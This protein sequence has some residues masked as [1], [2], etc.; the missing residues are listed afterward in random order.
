MRMSQILDRINK[1]NDIKNIEPKYYERLAGEIR[2]FLINK[3]SKSGGHF[4]SNLGVIELTMALHL[5]LD[6]P[7]DK[8]IWDVGHQAYAHKLLTGRKEGFN[9][10]RRYNGMAGFPKMEESDCDAFNVG[11]SS[12]SISVALG[13]ARARDINNENYKVYAVI[14]DGALSGGMAF[15]ALNNLARLKS[16]LVV[17]LNDNKMSI[18]ENVG[19]MANYLGKIRTAEKY[20]TLKTR[21]KRAIRK[22]PYG[23]KFI[24]ERIS[25][26]K[27]SI[28]RLVIPGMLFEDMGL[29]YIGPIDGHDINQLMYAFK[30]ASHAKGPVI[31]HVVTR[32]GKGY[33][34]A[35]KNPTK[36][37]GIDSNASRAEKD[38]NNGENV[39]YTTAFANK[40]IDIA[41]DNEKV[42]AVSAAML[43]G[44]GLNKFGALYPKRLFDV[45]IAEEHA[46]TF[47][48]G[49]AAGG[50]TPVVAIYSTF[51]QRAYDQ[52][53]H[54]ICI[55][56]HHVVLAIDR[57]GIVGPDGDTH[58][59]IYDT[60]FLRTIPNLT[61]M[62]PKNHR[63][64]DAMLEYAINEY[65]GPIAI[66]YPKGK[67]YTGLEEYQAPI[68]HG[69]AEIL[70]EEKEIMLVAF[71]SM[72]TVAYEVR[73]ML[74]ADGHRVS[75][76]N[77]RFATHIDFDTLKDLSVKHRLLVVLEE[78]VYTGGIGQEVMARMH[79]DRINIECMSVALPD[80][81][82]EH[83]QREFLLKK[84]GLDTESVY[85]RIKDV[86]DK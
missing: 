30:S 58:Q 49:M 40:L 66:R 36:Y 15:E 19:G 72:N 26:S 2:R 54:D 53:L 62:A 23:G 44:T 28:K 63:E 59:G 57:A 60:A 24:V 43:S 39:D 13:Y 11:H 45:G 31:V 41:K 33:K 55:S 14:G 35:E 67:V 34:L 61:L 68:E 21:I 78:N 47:A 75:L 65:N 16:N 10:L 73:E 4:A 3:V 37:H 69:K 50:L 7:K 84:Y 29:T 17:V 80:K 86:M 1:P 27:N 79:Q 18:S 38:K 70:Y 85:R 64:L 8:L 48:A 83:G 9:S 81:F 71:G 42:V 25:R 74:K 20:F 32:K 52:I 6:F 51:F 5:H 82:I 46:V 22:I 56:K 12:T 77:L 76:V